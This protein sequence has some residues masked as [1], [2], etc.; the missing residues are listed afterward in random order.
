[1]LIYIIM[2]R[3]IRNSSRQPLSILQ[4]NSSENAAV[5]R[6]GGLFSSPNIL[7][8]SIVKSLFN[9]GDCVNEF[10]R[11][12]GLT[13]GH[14]GSA[15]TRYSLKSLNTEDIQLHPNSDLQ[16]NSIATVS[17]YVP[18]ELEAEY[19]TS[20]NDDVTVRSD[21]SVNKISFVDASSSAY[22][23]A[24]VKIKFVDQ[25]LQIENYFQDPS[26]TWEANFDL[27]S[28]YVPT[29]NVNSQKAHTDRSVGVSVKDFN[30]W[31][32]QG[33]FGPFYLEGDISI[34]SYG[35]PSLIS[36]TDPSKNLSNYPEYTVELVSG[37]PVPD[38]G[39]CAL[40]VSTESA[41]QVESFD[42]LLTTSSSVASNLYSALTSDIEPNFNSSLVESNIPR[43]V[44]DDNTSNPLSD[45]APAEVIL[46]PG[47]NLQIT[48]SAH[49]S[50][51]DLVNNSLANPFS[52]NTSSMYFAPANMYALQNA[53]GSNDILN[54][55]DNSDNYVKITNG[56]LDLSG[57][58]ASNGSLTLGTDDEYLTSGQSDNGY[59]TFPAVNVI[60]GLSGESVYPRASKTSSSDS[61]HFNQLVVR[62]ESGDDSHTEIDVID[63]SLKTATDVSYNIKTILTNTL[64]DNTDYSGL[65]GYIG[66]SNESIALVTQA[67]STIT[68]SAITYDNANTSY[69]E[70]LY[71][72]DFAC[73]KNWMLNNLYD[74]CGNVTLSGASFNASGTNTNI[75][76][77]RDL[78]VQLDAKNVGDLTII[79]D[80]WSL[81]CADSYLTTS[82]EFDSCL[83]ASD[84]QSLLGGADL[85]SLTIT[86]GPAEG[87][88]VSAS[89]L[90]QFPDQ[91]AFSYNG[92]ISVT[93]N[94][95]FTVNP[96]SSTDLPITISQDAYS[97]IPSGCVLNK[98][99]LTTVFTVSI[100]F[101]LGAYTNLKLTTP[102]VTKTITYFTLT[103]DDVELPRRLL[104]GVTEIGVGALTS[105]LNNYKK[106]TKYALKADD[107][108]PYFITLQST[109]DD[110]NWSNISTKMSADMWYGN[111]TTIISSNGNFVF[112]FSF[113]L[114]LYS[115]DVEKIYGDL[116]LE[117]G[118]NTFTVSGKSFT[119]QQV[120]DNNFISFDFENDA[121]P[122]TYGTVLSLDTPTYTITNMG[123]NTPGITILSSSGY[124]FR[125][126][127]N[128]LLNLRVVVAKQTIFSVSRTV[129]ANED[130][131][132]KTISSGVLE[133]DTG[134]YTLG[135]LSVTHLGDYATWSL[136]NDHASVKLYNGHTM[137]TS[138]I[139]LD[140]TVNGA[141][142]DASN[143]IL[144]SRGVTFNWNRGY[145]VGT[146]NI[147]RTVT[148]VAFN[149]SG[150]STDY[151]VYYNQVRNPFGGLQTTDQ[152]S[153][154][155]TSVTSAQYWDLKL[156]SYGT[157]NIS[158]KNADDASN[159]YTV[160]AYNFII[161][162]GVNKSFVNNTL[163]TINFDYRM[164]YSGAYVDLYRIADYTNTSTI[165]ADYDYIS[166]Y[167]ET[168]L[169]KSDIDNIIGNVLNL[170]LDASS[171]M[172]DL[173]VFF[174]VC[175]PFISFKVIDPSG[176]ANIPFTPQ[177]QNYKTYYRAVDSSGNTYNPFDS[178][179][180]INNI[181]FNDTRGISYLDFLRPTPV[182]SAQY[183]MVINNYNFI[184]QMKQ[185]LYDV[186]SN[187]ITYYDGLIQATSDNASYSFGPLNNQSGI[188]RVELN[189][190]NILPGFSD[191]SSDIDPSTMYDLYNLKL[192][193]GSA[194]IDNGTEI[195]L[196]F[197]A[198]EA[199][200]YT[201]YVIDEISL[202]SGSM[203]ATVS[204]YFNDGDLIQNLSTTLFNSMVLTY[205]SKQSVTYSKQLRTTLPVSKQERG[206]FIKS[207]AQA[208]SS[209][210]PITW[211]A[212]QSVAPGTLLRLQPLTKSALTDIVSSYSVN[213]NI[214]Q[215]ITLYDLP[216][217]AEFRDK[218]GNLNSK[219]KYDG[220]LE[221]PSISL[222]SQQDLESSGWGNP[223]FW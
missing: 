174:A 143:T 57:G 196:E 180:T 166:S 151:N 118:K 1:M 99:A 23:D 217:Q 94:D 45:F 31:N 85:R 30:S 206:D 35:M 199:V 114:T 177:I 213:T 46:Q 64:G 160:P 219:V 201:S 41:Y 60:S 169:K 221:I 26:G 97:G 47:F 63:T 216:N 120:L 78:R 18:T 123:N 55:Y 79:Q 141:Y 38:F 212:K 167:H 207:I 113:P 205:N 119:A 7:E 54:T 150:Y 82:N 9:N 91:I 88:S 70:A 10:A 93:Y 66:L 106:I 129:D 155:A 90:V 3:P 209:S 37:T 17:T 74:A 144:I 14:N 149:I 84:I 194:F 126:P 197:V 58:N 98:K 200:S 139:E 19:S 92:H 5:A 108:K 22:M 110:I 81:S 15:L 138:Q 42:T 49:G 215:T 161:W 112:D 175:P 24:T 125:H 172:V 16:F 21:Y 195:Y 159:N 86:Y 104:S 40:K 156:A 77:H 211:S 193:V 68:P 186:S 183:N 71:I 163:N 29:R 162:Q 171:S 56:S 69:P 34:D 28:N 2:I 210:V 115:L 33:N 50:S 184:V 146:T 27:S 154:Y 124:S 103:K 148:H 36:F 100:P 223:L 168:S 73:Q 190:L 20:S 53:V 182:D 165:I 61:L 157:Y 102:M 127:N 191:M 89:K 44:G 4:G 128:L 72:V 43:V 222:T 134:I 152:I 204:R 203:H 147:N 140:Q 96:I 137:S 25:Y 80:G 116:S 145:N 179:T 107:L 62:Y 111:S 187:Y 109:V 142:L 52:I 65:S 13:L 164:S 8:N 6:I 132:F 181:T 135:D 170:H 188:F 185:G 131:Y 105:T 208:I 198:G 83:Q 67:N 75:S 32:T 101:R 51:I 176:V 214:P 121:I 130:I 189:Q 122:S 153:M 95:E 76:L 39:R 87:S 133:V 220:T 117:K 178:S 158:Y 192:T 59:V 12:S 218:S 173:L 136:N 202:Q 11:Q 48:S